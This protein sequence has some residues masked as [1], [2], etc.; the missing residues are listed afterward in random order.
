MSEIELPNTEELEGA[1]GQVFTRRVALVTAV[2]AVVL[3]ITVHVVARDRA[4]RLMLAG[5]LD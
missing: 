1:K 3:A 5:N 2:Y 4:R